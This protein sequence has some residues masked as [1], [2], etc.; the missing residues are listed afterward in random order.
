MWVYF[1][2]ASQGAVSPNFHNNSI[3]GDDLVL[4]IVHTVRK[5]HGQEDNK[6]LY[7]VILTIKT[8]KTKNGMYFVYIF[9]IMYV[10]TNAFAYCNFNKTSLVCV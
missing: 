8:K 6:Y 10:T 3:A 9:V 7:S 5:R 1:F 4:T 2:L